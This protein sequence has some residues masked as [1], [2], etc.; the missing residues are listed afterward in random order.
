MQRTGQGRVITT[1]PRG[2]CSAQAVRRSEG[3]RGRGGR[4][5]G[6]PPL[7]LAHS[8]CSETLAP[9]PRAWLPRPFAHVRLPRVPKKPLPVG[10][11][12][13]AALTC[14]DGSSRSQSAERRSSLPRGSAACCTVGP[15]AGRGSRDPEGTRR[16]LARCRQRLR[17][18][19]RATPGGGS[20]HVPG[21]AGR[22]GKR[23]HGPQRAALG[24]GGAAGSAATAAAPPVPCGVGGGL[25]RLVRRARWGPA[26]RA[27][28]RARSPGI[29]C[30]RPWQTKGSGDPAGGRTGRGAEAGET[31]PGSGWGLGWAGLGLGTE[32]SLP[33]PSL[34]ATRQDT[35][36]GEGTH[37]GR[38]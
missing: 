25:P 26:A 9:S 31:K 16:P 20:A 7:G 36:G 35:V 3:P 32:L 23:K 24:P 5:A 2:L 4:R 10:A 33:G 19:L 14:A 1:G 27:G 12:P 13:T 18:G 38:S 28:Q 8:G 30:E 37:S 29:G 34:K 17:C 11:A 21:A 15:R 6:C 22:D